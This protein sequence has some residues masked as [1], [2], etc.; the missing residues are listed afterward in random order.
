MNK[1][2]LME[3]LKYLNGNKEVAQIT[4]DNHDIKAAENDREGDWL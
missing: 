3:E 4:F 2:E 1:D